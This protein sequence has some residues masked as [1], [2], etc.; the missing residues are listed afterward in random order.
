MRPRTSGSLAVRA[1]PWYR[2]WGADFTGVIYP[3]QAGNVA[4]L[5]RGQLGL[6]GIL[7]GRLA[8][9]LVG[10]DAECAQ[11]AVSR[12]N[13]PVDR[14]KFALVHDIAAGLE[15][16]RFYRETIRLC[17]KVAPIPGAIFG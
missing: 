3:H 11:Y 12:F 2:A 8:L 1:W 4:A 10:I 9:S 15:S 16:G 14:R 6:G 13:Q 5:L 17:Q 7:G